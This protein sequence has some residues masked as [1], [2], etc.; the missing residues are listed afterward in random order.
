MDIGNY[1]ITTDGVHLVEDYE[2]AADKAF[3]QYEVDWWYAEACTY[4]EACER[5]AMYDQ[6]MNPDDFEGYGA[7]DEAA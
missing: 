6:G 5:A 7:Y 3:G 1:L 4:E 2:D